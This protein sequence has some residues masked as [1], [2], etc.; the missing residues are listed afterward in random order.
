MKPEVG[1]D[2]LCITGTCFVN[3]D[4]QFAR[5]PIGGWNCHYILVMQII[6]RLELS[7]A[8]AEHP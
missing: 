7:G 1:L 8:A 3:R 6:C 4:P 2:F 5:T